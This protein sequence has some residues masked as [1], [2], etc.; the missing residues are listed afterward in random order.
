MSLRPA[1][2]HPGPDLFN[3]FAPPFARSWRRAGH[4]QT[5]SFQAGAP[6]RR[7]SGAL[8]RSFLARWTTSAAATLPSPIGE[9][10][11]GVHIGATE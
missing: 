3:D 2:E 6:T 11:T 4:W 1:C 7:R 8:P 10:H 5:S 9:H